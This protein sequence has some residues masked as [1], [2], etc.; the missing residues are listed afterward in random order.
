MRKVILYRTEGIFLESVPVPEHM[1]V[2]HLHIKD[3][4]PHNSALL[5]INQMHPWINFPLTLFESWMN[6]IS[7]HPR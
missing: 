5:N 1:P 3:H 7:S 4:K 6:H 2:T